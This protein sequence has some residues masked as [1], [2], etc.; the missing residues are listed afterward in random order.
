M[1]RYNK[2]LNRDC[3]DCGAPF[4]VTDRQEAEGSGCRRCPKCRPGKQGVQ[5]GGKKR[6]QICPHCGGK[7]AYAAKECRECWRETPK[8]GVSDE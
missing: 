2:P 4:R 3:E 1:G 6:W 5:R 7:K 8:Q